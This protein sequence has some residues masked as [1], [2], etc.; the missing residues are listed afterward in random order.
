RSCRAGPPTGAT[1]CWPFWPACR[2]AHL[3]ATAAAAQVFRPSSSKRLLVSSPSGS[4]PPPWNSRRTP[5]WTTRRCSRGSRPGRPGRL[6][7]TGTMPRR[8][9]LTQRWRKSG[10]RRR[11][12]PT[13]PTWRASASHTSSTTMR[14]TPCAALGAMRRATRLGASRPSSLRRWTGR[15]GTCNRTRPTGRPSRPRSSGGTW[16]PWTSS[17]TQRICGTSARASWGT[18]TPRTG[19]T[20]KTWRASRTGSSAAT[21]T[22]ALPTSP[23]SCR[24]PRTRMRTCPPRR[25]ATRRAV[26]RRPSCRGSCARPY[27]GEKAKTFSKACK[28]RRRS[29][30]PSTGSC[31]W[32]WGARFE[33]ML[34]ES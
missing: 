26:A 13:R 11:T 32:D 14:R 2:S 9:A 28:L 33:A 16:L 20:R 23:A 25:R 15:R 22:L 6:G 18:S 8:S 27:A 30:W 7:P 1:S 21:C 12:R 19:A 29:W 3:A 17:A 34:P 31:E 24:W 4:A 10:S 5:P